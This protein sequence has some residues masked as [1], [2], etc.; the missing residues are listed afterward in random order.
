[1]M[2]DS[3]PTSDRRVGSDASPTPREGLVDLLTFA[4]IAAARWFVARVLREIRVPLDQ[5]SLFGSRARGEGRPDSDVDVLLIFEWLP[6]DREPFASQAERIAMQVAS[7]T[8]VPVTVWSVS[9][10]DLPEGVRT[11]MLVDALE[12]SVPI[13]CR[14][15]AVPPL[16]FT[17]P[18]A[19]RCTTALLERISEGSEEFGSHLRAGRLESAVRRGRD[20]LVRLCTAALLTRGITRPRRAEAVVCFERVYSNGESPG[21]GVAPVLRWAADSFGPDGRGEDLPLSPPPGGEPALAR[22]VERLRALVVR[23]RGRL[24]RI[25]TLRDRSL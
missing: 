25:H 18:D 1:M 2:P 16:P 13:W 22:A 14:G 4:E 21:P 3:L 12:D 9:R 23:E 8:G 11:P 17:P 6:P 24:G 7:E 10:P 19:L 20:D 15:E 5:A